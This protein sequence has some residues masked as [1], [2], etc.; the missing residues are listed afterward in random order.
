MKYK[1]IDSIKSDVLFESY[2]KD[3]KS[4]FE[5]SAEAMFKIICNISKVKKKSKISIEVTGE[6]EKDLLYNWLQELIAKVDIETMFFS[7]FKINSITPILLKAD[8]YGEQITPKLGRTVVK[9]VTYYKFSLEK[10][11][12]GYKAVISVDI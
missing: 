10:T 4:L 2:G 8:I 11:D 9:A 6:N 1:F 3:L 5:N 7:S 12:K